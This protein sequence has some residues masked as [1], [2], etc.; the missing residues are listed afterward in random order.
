MGAG[1]GGE[2]DGLAA[3]GFGGDAGHYYRGGEGVASTR[4]VASCRCTWRYGMTGLAPRNIGLDIRDAGPL[5]LRKLLHPLV[6]IHQR[7]PLPHTQRI[8]RLFTLL[9]THHVRTA[10]LLDIAQPFGDGHEGERIHGG[11]ALFWIV[12]SSGFGEFVEDSRGLGE[13]RAVHRVF[14]FEGYFRG[15]DGG[16]VFVRRGAVWRW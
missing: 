11:P 12:G 14:Y 10:V 6:N 16:Q 4:G 3:G 5:H 7:I 9:P 2:D 15:E 1:R 13:G 8:E